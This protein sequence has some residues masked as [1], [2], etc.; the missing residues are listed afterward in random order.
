MLV[1]RHEFHQALTALWGQLEVFEQRFSRKLEKFMTDVNS[2]FNYLD[3]ASAD[4]EGDIT[5]LQQQIAS[6]D[7]A[8][9]QALAAQIEQRVAAMRTFAQQSAGGTTT[10]QPPAGDT[11]TGT[12]TD[13]G[14]PTD[15][16]TPTV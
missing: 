2:A 3:S 7:Q 4:M 10:T 5:T 13:T 14:T 8:G 16:G 12:G 9:A 15:A 11:G 6:G 1:T